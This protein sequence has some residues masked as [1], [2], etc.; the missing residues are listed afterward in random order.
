MA[1]R[2]SH[3]THGSRRNSRRPRPRRRFSYEARQLGATTADLPE[4]LHGSLIGW[5]YELLTLLRRTRREN[6]D[7]ERNPPHR[8]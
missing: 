3:P 1:N 2:S 7:P 5:L 6:P 8:P 4:P